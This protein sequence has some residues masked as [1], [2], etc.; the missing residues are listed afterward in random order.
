MQKHPGAPT[1]FAHAP[2]CTHAHSVAQSP[3]THR[4]PL[5]AVRPARPQP[6]HAV[7]HQSVDMYLPNF[8]HVCN[9]SGLMVKL[10][11]FPATNQGSIP[12]YSMPTVVQVL[13]YQGDLSL[14]FLCAFDNYKGGGTVTKG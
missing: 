1:S 13:F 2:T 10:A 3:T 4:Q 12:R 9:C 11:A 7:L 5:A 6:T 14:A 8:L